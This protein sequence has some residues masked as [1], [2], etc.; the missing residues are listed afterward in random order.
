M[1]KRSAAIA[2][3]NMLGN[4]ANVYGPYMYPSSDGPRYLPGGAAVAGLCFVVAGLAFNLRLYVPFRDTI[5]NY[6]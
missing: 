5:A 1:V 2:I 3:C 4:L 6:H